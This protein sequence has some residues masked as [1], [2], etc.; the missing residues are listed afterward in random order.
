MHHK[1]RLASVSLTL[2]LAVVFLAAA[3]GTAAQ[4]TYVPVGPKKLTVVAGQPFEPVATS[5]D[6][7][8]SV[9][10]CP[11]ETEPATFTVSYAK[12][13][14]NVRVA[15]TGDFVG[16]GT[17]GRLNFEVSR[18]EGNDLVHDISKTSGA[19]YALADIG[20]KPTQF[21][22]NVTVPKRTPPGT[23]KGAIG[24]YYQNKTFD[25]VTV[26]V[27]VRPL[28]LLGSSKQY[29][30]YTN[31]GP[32]GAGDAQAYADFAG[33]VAKLGFDSMSIS[34]GPDD[35][36]S[37]LQAYTRA[38]FTRTV[39]LTTY[40][41][42]TMPSTE[43]VSKIE[44]A[45]Q[46]VGL[47]GALYFCKDQP[48]NEKDAELIKVQAY[49]IRRARAKAIVTVADDTVLVLLPSRLHGLNYDTSMQYTQSLIAGEQSRS[50][51]MWQWCW[52]DAGQSVS[53]NR[54]NSGMALW[55]SGLDGCMPAWNPG[56]CKPADSLLTEALRE[57]IDDTRYITTYMKA[58]R[59]L[60]DMK[61]AKDNEYISATEAY[62]KSFLNKPLDQIT[63]ADLRQLRSKMAEYSVNLAAKLK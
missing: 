16:P 27:Q 25:V 47:P 39:P 8:V 18:V 22:L 63:V 28:R 60:K 1:Y 35:I 9:T 29:I 46:S 36:Q 42:G 12:P 30:L 33:S 40:A 45:V 14:E 31:C 24:F 48:I 23:Y 2:L 57:G 32:D 44:A 21:W 10:L 4:K 58:L 49:A 50:A 51:S 55:R 37:A 11:E 62:L 56:V 3:A 34:A 52:W 59:E 61:R 6:S 20:Q 26:Q 13:L 5:G 15:A 19:V 41:D 43:D 53:Q 54:I 7:K 17:I 38:G